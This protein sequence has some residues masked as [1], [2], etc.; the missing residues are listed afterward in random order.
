M[1]LRTLLL[2]ASVAALTATAA[3]A[4]TTYNQRHSI[5]ARESNQQARIAHGVK[6]GQITPKGAAAAEHNQ[7]RISA[8]DHSMRQADNGHL[9]AA[10]R[11]TLARQQNRASKGI[12][13]RNHNQY[14]DPGV[15][16]K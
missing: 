2:V 10:D 16:P 4:Q 3:S 1:N 12:Y 13:D 15:A 5:N 7:A 6:D 9:T 14:T 11:H 8:E